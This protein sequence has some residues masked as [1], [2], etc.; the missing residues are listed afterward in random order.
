MSR[1]KPTRSLASFSGTITLPSRPPTVPVSTAGPTVIEPISISVPEVIQVRA[2]SIRQVETVE[3]IIKRV[4]IRSRVPL[5]NTQ[6]RHLE[7]LRIQGDQ[8]LLSV[9]DR[10]SIYEF[11]GLINK[12]GYDDAIKFFESH[13]IVPGGKPPLTVWET[14]KEVIRDMPTMIDARNK[15]SR[16]A[17]IFTEKLT[18]VK[19][20][21][22]CGKC[23]SEETT[24]F[25]RQ[26]RSL[27][28]AAS[29]F[30]TCVSCGNRWRIG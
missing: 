10:S 18:T 16:D 29:I 13:S 30:V 8:P 26:T 19:G 2:P 27:D 15:F 22:K 23:G 21:F 4:N 6:I 24:Y 9:D 11:L 17:G 1:S 25:E 12:I 28:E 3:T 14:R 5:D 20:V 7:S